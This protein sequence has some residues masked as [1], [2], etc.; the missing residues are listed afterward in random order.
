MAYICTYCT[1]ILNDSYQLLHYKNS[2]V[3]CPA[4]CY[5][6]LLL[7]IN[8]IFCFSIK[9]PL[10]WYP[11][12][13]VLKILKK[14]KIFQ[15][16]GQ[17]RHFAHESGVMHCICWLWVCYRQFKVAIMLLAI[18]LTCHIIFCHFFVFFD[19]FQDGGSKETN[20]AQQYDSIFLVCW[21]GACYLSLSTGIIFVVIFSTSCC[22][23]IY[24]YY[25]SVSAC[26][27][28]NYRCQKRKEF[29][30]RKISYWM[31]NFI[32]TMQL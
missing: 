31:I 28:N 1:C 19:F 24:F 2:D 6:C 14:F 9:F 29:D 16:G 32:I 7:Q 27:A 10:I 18:N 4:F 20:F 30:K 26:A 21:L 22:F 13:L 15:D 23:F 3:F 11:T 25:T 12:W 8:S 5:G 17:N